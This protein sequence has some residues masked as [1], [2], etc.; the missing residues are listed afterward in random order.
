MENEVE[1]LGWVNRDQRK[2]LLEK[3]DVLV[4]PSYNEGLPMA[5]L[6]AMS[7]GLPIIST[8]VGSIAEAVHNGENGFLVEPGNVAALE[9]AITILTDNEELWQRQSLAS[10]K[11]CETKFAETVFFRKI[12]KIYVDLYGGARK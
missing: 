9:E 7:Y 10:R 11:T 1:F 5:I 2:E 8:N 6:E 12:Q 4:L 3:S